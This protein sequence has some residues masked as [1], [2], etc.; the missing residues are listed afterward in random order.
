MKIYNISVTEIDNILHFI[1]V[2]LMEI[3]LTRNYSEL[4]KRYYHQIL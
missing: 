2:T 1:I 4:S 3:V